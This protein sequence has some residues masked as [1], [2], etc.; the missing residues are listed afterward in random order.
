MTALAHN[1]AD[2]AGPATTQLAAL[3]PRTPQEAVK[4]RGWQPPT[5]E[6]IRILGFDRAWCL[7]AGARAGAM[8]HR[9]WG[10]RDTYRGHDGWCRAG[11][12]DPNGRRVRAA[13]AAPRPA[14]EQRMAELEQRLAL[15]TSARVA[16]EAAAA[17]ATRCMVQGA[18]CALVHA[19]FHTV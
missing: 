9:P 11:E 18:G 12:L 16:A 15:E 14:L 19:K 17:S 7:P 8:S 3:R 1:I 13:A 6:Q 4:I 2:P 5:A 10:P